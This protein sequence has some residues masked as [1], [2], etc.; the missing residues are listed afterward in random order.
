M[1]HIFKMFHCKQIFMIKRRN[2]GEITT[3]K[4][5]SHCLRP[6]LIQA[7]FPIKGNC[8]IS[9]TVNDKLIWYSGTRLNSMIFP[10]IIV[11][12][13]VLSFVTKIMYSY[14]LSFHYKQNLTFDTPYVR[15]D[16]IAFRFMIKF[17][18]KMISF[19]V[20]EFP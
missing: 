20:D 4:W 1:K 19:N 16:L 10:S 5:E 2:S 12:S 14:H 9:D 7:R 18:N 17:R 3:N 8:L 11:C 15:R 13:S 6:R